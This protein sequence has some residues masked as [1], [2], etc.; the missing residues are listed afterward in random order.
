MAMREAII[1]SAKL[2]AFGYELAWTLEDNRLLWRNCANGENGAIALSEIAEAQTLVEPAL[3]GPSQHLCRLRTRSGARFAIPAMH[4]SGAFRREDRSASWNKLMGA[5]LQQIAQNAPQAR[6][7][8][9]LSPLVYPSPGRNLWS[10]SASLA[11]PTASRRDRVQR[12]RGVAFE[13]DSP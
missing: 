7:R 8:R 3:F 11:R 6:V 4:S 13:F 12:L 1:H 9:G 2:G 10:G 5:L